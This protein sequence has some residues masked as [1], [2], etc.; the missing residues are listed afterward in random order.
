MKTLKVTIVLAVISLTGCSANPVLH[1][2]DARHRSVNAEQGCVS[3]ARS[4]VNQP[5]VTAFVQV[6]SGLSLV[7][8][9]ARDLLVM[10]TEL[11]STL[12]EQRQLNRQLVAELSDLGEAKKIGN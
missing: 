4:V 1:P 12:L 3:G 8:E 5:I 11:R 10:P 2:L 6:T 7:F 9:S